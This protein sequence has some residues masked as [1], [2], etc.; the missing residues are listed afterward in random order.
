MEHPHIGLLGDSLRVTVYKDDA[1]ILLIGRTEPTLFPRMVHCPDVLDIVIA[2]AVPSQLQ[3][4]AVA[5]L[6]RN[7]F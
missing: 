6:S 7:R 2:K 3:V 5:D 1:S 4:S